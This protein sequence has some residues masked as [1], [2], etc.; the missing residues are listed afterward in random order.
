MASARVPFFLSSLTKS[1]RPCLAL[2]DRIQIGWG[3]R[4]RGKNLLRE[5]EIQAF[6]RKS[7]PLG[8]LSRLPDGGGLFL[9]VSPH[10]TAL[11]RYKYRIPD[12]TRPDGVKESLL[13]LGQ[14]PDVGLQDAR[15][16]RDRAREL[17]EQG[18]DPIFERE[19][20]RQREAEARGNT[21]GDVAQA[22]LEKNQ[23]G[24]SET[25]F[26]TTAGRID[27]HL[28]NLRAFPISKIEDRT[29]GKI[30]EGIVASGTIVEAHKIHQIVRSIF[31]YGMALGYLTRNPADSAIELIPRRRKKG[32]RP[33]FEDWGPLGDILKRAKAVQL[34]RAV[35]M[36]HRLC[37][38]TAARVGTVISAEWIEFEELDRETPTWVIPREKMKMQDR[39]HPHRVMLGP[40]IAS[41]LRE[42]RRLRGESKFL[43]PSPADPREHITSE[44]ISKMYRVTLGLDKKHTPHGWRAA[45]STLANE[46]GFDS[47]AVEMALDHIH[48]SDVVRAYDRGERLPERVKLAKWWDEMLS[49]AERGDL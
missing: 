34:S 43:F 4:L 46:N 24:W 30:I 10:G 45:F 19:Q 35:H 14:Y 23:R 33:A 20:A 28:K 22:W 25:H 12:A 31:R 39:H 47:N 21:F 3:I 6:V 37:A 27:R 38:F 5:K 16:K 49:K 41:E 11:W 26:D 8:K 29:V 40:T 15:K 7:K 36:A 2:S 48:A 32:R 13:A 18:L 9:I 17:V 42:W 44:S 1:V